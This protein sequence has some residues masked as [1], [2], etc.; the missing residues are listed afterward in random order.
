MLRL[1]G[2][3]KYYYSGNNIVLALRKIDIEFKTGEFIAITG[4]SGSGKSTLLNV[5]SGLDVY[6]DGKMLVN[7]IDVSHYTVNELEVYRK[8][9]IGFVFQEY[10][11]IDSY[12]VF[13]NIELAL[14]VQGYDKSKR[15]ARVLELIEKVGLK[16]V[17]HQKASKC[18]GGEKQ[19][20]VIARALAK[21]C[22]II[23]CD[24]PTGNLDSES[25]NNILKLLH[26]I[27]AEKLVIV[28]THNFEEIKEF[29]TRKVRLY[30]G[31]IV[32]DQI[33]DKEYKSSDTFKELAPYKAKLTDIL[34]ISLLNIL[35][36]PKKTFFSL[37][38]IT[39]MIFSFI[40]A[41]GLSLK[42]QNTSLDNSTPYI[43]NA[44]QSR[45]IV[46]KR[47]DS[48]FSSDELS[49]IDD[50]EY[51]RGVVEYDL[52]FDSIFISVFENKEYGYNEFIPFK[53]LAS[54][55]LNKFDLSKGTLP[56][57][58][59]E[60]VM[61]DNEYYT[62]GDYISISNEF[63]IKKI[64]GAITDQYTFKIVG[65]IEQNVNLSDG[66]NELYF[67]ID[68]LY[69]MHNTAIYENAQKYLV[70]DDIAF[71]SLVQDVRIDDSLDDMEVLAYDMMFFDICRDFGYRK[72]V[73]DDFDAG[74]CDFEYIRYHDF[75]I[76][77]FTKYEP[78]NNP[79]DIVLDSVPIYPHVFGQG[80]YMNTDTFN[81]I[82]EDDIYQPSVIVYDMFE[83]KQVKEDLEELGYNVFYPNGVIN[84]DDAMLIVLRN[85]QL[86]LTLGLSLVVVYFVG[87]FVMRNVIISK[88]KDY[89]VY[90][91]VG[92]SK[93]MI[94]WVLIVE[95][96]YLTIASFTVVIGLL[97]MN[98][99]F[100]SVIPRLLR[101]FKFYNYLSILIIVNL[102]M[103]IMSRNFNSRIFGKSVIS[104]LKAE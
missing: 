90:R 81:F 3:S 17:T 5:L 6:E 2:L 43:E 83:A 13:Q 47:D 67:H 41:Y 42:E 20:T 37:L 85:I 30:D 84:E 14:I 26:D 74:L 68:A 88:K 46:T 35:S 97:L 27:S 77:S 50:I 94:N 9:Y 28:V 49:V 95:I 92:A 86:I 22:S 31:E 99:Q 60:V 82:F 45:L 100:D 72:E 65:I 11:I 79:V 39:L 55:S 70:I 103:F 18:S 69:E 101:Y 73:I 19:R 56:T 7:N 66:L 57:Q 36:V 48:A 78:L 58:E 1:E 24:E 33:I 25:S 38:I 44:N 10:N 21:D 63:I 4:E 61:G 23:V 12:T 76:N 96:M 62:I 91:S 87:Y 29:A 51:V 16:G 75:S 53:V 8:Q 52:V 32:E 80:I 89:L 64:D 104:S 102:V 15:K 71:Y 34:K 59:N 93:T 40:F 98:E 54:D